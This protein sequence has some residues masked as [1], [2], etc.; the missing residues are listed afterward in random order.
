MVSIELKIFHYISFMALI[1]QNILCQTA[2]HENQNN[3]SCRPSIDRA[4]PGGDVQ[5]TRN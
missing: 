4:S 1:P 2:L 5:R 3:L